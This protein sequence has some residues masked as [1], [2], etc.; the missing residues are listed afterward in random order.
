MPF[1]I[2]KR[3]KGGTKLTPFSRPNNIKITDIRAGF[4][5]KV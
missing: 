5:L 2:F 3:K 1:W 4:F